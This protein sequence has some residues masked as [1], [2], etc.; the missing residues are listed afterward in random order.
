MANMDCGLDCTE[1]KQLRSSRR[2]AC[3]HKRRADYERSLKKRSARFFDRALPVSHHASRPHRAARAATRTWV[4][5]GKIECQIDMPTIS[6]GRVGVQKPSVSSLLMYTSAA[7]SSKFEEKPDDVNSDVETHVSDGTDSIQELAISETMSPALS[8]GVVDEEM[9]H[10]LSQ[11]NQLS[12]GDGTSEN[13]ATTPEEI[14]ITFESRVSASTEACGP[15]MPQAEDA[16]LAKRE[17]AEEQ[18]NMRPATFM[19]ETILRDLVKQLKNQVREAEEQAKEAR[20]QAHRSMHELDMPRRTGGLVLK[21]Q[22]LQVERQRAAQVRKQRNQAAHMQAMKEK[23]NR[24]LQEAEDIRNQAEI[25]AVSMRAQA[26]AE[27][28]RTAQEEVQA[29][30]KSQLALAKAEADSLKQD[31]LELAEKAEKAKAEAEARLELALEQAE[32]ERHA[33]AKV[34]VEAQA[35]QAE[36]MRTAQEIRQKALQDAVAW[37]ERCEAQMRQRFEVESRA[38]QEAEAKRAEEEEESAF[39]AKREAEA[40]AQREAARARKL[41]KEMDL[42]RSRKFHK[43]AKQERCQEQ[44]KSHMIDAMKKQIEEES[45]ALKEKAIVEIAA[46]RSQAKAEAS[47]VTKKAEVFAESI[48]QRALEEA[49]ELK[50]QVCMVQASL[51]EEVSTGESCRKPFESEVEVDHCDDDQE[52]WEVL[53]GQSVIQDADWDVM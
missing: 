11:E 52:D 22:A 23:A 18:D 38:H 24:Q 7:S 3:L 10:K 15:N 47:A 42:Q 12:L 27:A 6:M 2:A 37:K 34:V 36:A 13:Q 44:M 5:K 8:F 29:Q 49:R 51:Q 30:V 41:A 35:M 26:L 43:Q 14:G 4:A 9:A 40:Q 46:M 39:C 21:K 28:S 1:L 16:E 19:R 50:Q 31:S 53:P 45:K 20:A 33:A 25:E 48:K 17:E 32:N